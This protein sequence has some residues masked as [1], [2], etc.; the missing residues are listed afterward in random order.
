M[1]Q[2]NIFFRGFKQGFRNF[3]HTLTNIINF[4][5]LLVVYLI[6]IGMVSVTSKLFGKH[7]LELKKTNSKSSWC[8][9]NVIKQ[10][11]EKYYRMF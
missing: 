3:S 9:H 1:I 4:F 5:L 6:G 7:Y 8:E 10:P 11:L 2:T